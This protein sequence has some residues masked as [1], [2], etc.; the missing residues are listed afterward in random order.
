MTGLLHR[1]A[2]RANG[3]AWAVRSDARLPF[4]ADH[5]PPEG[6]AAQDSQNPKAPGEAIRGMEA[7]LDAA[8]PPH[9][10]AK[11][12]TPAT[13]ATS[14]AVPP[15]SA[16][17]HGP[18][19]AQDT[20]PASPPVLTGPGQA[21][22]ASAAALAAGRALQQPH[23]PGATDA[24]S[25]PAQSATSTRSAPQAPTVRHSDWNA[26][27]ENTVQPGPA[28][29]WGAEPAPL[30]PPVDANASPSGM[31]TPRQLAALRAMG[32][33]QQSQSSQDTEVH[34]HIGRIDVTAVHEKPQPKARARERE[35]TQP[36]SLDAY[37][38]ARSSK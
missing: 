6:G 25:V 8:L 20:Q 36:V 37:L 27:R 31:D 32:A 16:L 11:A 30:L 14:T 23:A 3:T 21:K 28:P 38:A 1:L 4:G 34:I 2:A 7:P 35:R 13:A 29:H 9:Q 19:P 5:L 18:P 22:P 10:R 12:A 15:P 17:P 33:A 24:A 26:A